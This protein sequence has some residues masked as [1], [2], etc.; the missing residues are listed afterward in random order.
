MLHTSTHAPV[1]TATRQGH[2]LL[3]EDDWELAEEICAALA[4]RGHAVDHVDDGAEG[5]A[6]ARLGTF[7]LL[8]ADRMLP[9]MDGLAMIE[10]L[11]AIGVTM[12]VLVLSALTAVDERVRGLQAGGDDYLTKP[13]AL[14][15]LAARV[16]ALL[17]R[18]VQTRETKLSVAPLTLDLIER[19]A[20]RGERQI[21]LLPTEF[22]ILEY[23]MRRAGQ[24]MTRDM[25]LEG[26]WHY[27]FLP[28]TN[29]VDVHMGKLRRK[30]DAPGE[31]PMIH[32]IRGAGFMLRPPG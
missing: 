19:T 8:I 5:L 21:D 9:G 1:A 10:N 30:V 4:A 17:R 25:L 11:R 32:S 28:H 22:K 20:W 6:R 14:V 26:V 31:P 23:M 24:V 27:R 18:P 7:D 15:E 29:I 2:L 12:P 3:V 16:E 13:V